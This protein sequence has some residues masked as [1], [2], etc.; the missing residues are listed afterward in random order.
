MSE[1]SF[2]CNEA[3]EPESFEPLPVNTEAVSEIIE[4]EYCEPNE[5]GTRSL[6]L[7]VR[8]LDGEYKGKVTQERYS[9]VCPT[10]EIAVEIAQRSLR[11]ICEAI[12]MTGFTMTEELHNKPMLVKY[13][14]DKPRKDGDPIYNNIKSCKPY[15]ANVG[16]TPFHA[17]APEEPD[18]I[19]KDEARQEAA[20]APWAK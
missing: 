2:N 20:K 4:S 18:E 9:L 13:G 1:L 6:I 15:G 14:Q 10:S 16:K 12:N 8:V 5:K 11:Q 7:K 3:P 17:D 19:D